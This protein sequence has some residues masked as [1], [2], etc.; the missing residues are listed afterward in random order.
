MIEPHGQDLTG[1]VNVGAAGS[2]CALWFHA[3]MASASALSSSFFTVRQLD[4]PCTFGL[5][6]QHCEHLT[7]QLLGQLSL[8]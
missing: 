2:G 1:H 6:I 3:S 7:R 8:P 5:S 4:E